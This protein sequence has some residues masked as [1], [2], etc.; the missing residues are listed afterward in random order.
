MEKARKQSKNISFILKALLFSYLI[1]TSL[2][3]LL[4][5]FMLKCSLSG[6]VISGSIHAIYILSA[7]VGGFLAGKRVEEKR[8]LWGLLMGVAYF[9]V[10][11]IFSILMNQNAS[12]P[13]GNLL[14]VL[15]ICSG[16]GMVGGMLS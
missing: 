6:G 15:A 9:I 5:F 11:A 13:I 12:L 7:F 10:I 14:A 2:L 3:L 16:S 1:T 4:S 8:Y